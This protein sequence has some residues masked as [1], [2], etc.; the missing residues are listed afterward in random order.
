MLAMLEGV[1]RKQI[2][3]S[4]YTPFLLI[5]IYSLLCIYKGPG[6][7]GYSLVCFHSLKSNA[8]AFTKG[9]KD[10]A[11]RVPRRARKCGMGKEGWG[12]MP[13][14]WLWSPV[15]D[16][17][18]LWKGVMAVLI[19]GPLFALLLPLGPD[20]AREAS[21]NMDLVLWSGSGM[22]GGGAGEFDSPWSIL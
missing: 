16:V 10:M 20:L 2:I 14:S 3:D 12:L 21:H 22:E 15:G 8:F 1:E 5:Y 9:V 11:H 7:Q 6:R 19:H 18:Q 4:M 13:V 17:C